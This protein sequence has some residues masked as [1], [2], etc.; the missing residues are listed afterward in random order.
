MLVLSRIK[1]EGLV[2]GEDIVVEVVEVTT[3]KVRLGI[4]CPKEVPVHRQEVWDAIQRS[5]SAPAPADGDE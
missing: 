2:I 1:G 4:M 3:D 5:A